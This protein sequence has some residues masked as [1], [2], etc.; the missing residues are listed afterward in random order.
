MKGAHTSSQ[1][2]SRIKGSRYYIEEGIVS[3]KWGK[4][5]WEVHH[6]ISDGLLYSSGGSLS[7]AFVGLAYQGKDI[8][9]RFIIEYTS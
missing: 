8:L 6:L 9:F 1:F 7:L 5:A 2:C 3:V 4:D